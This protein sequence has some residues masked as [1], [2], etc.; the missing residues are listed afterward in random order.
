[1]G[2]RLGRKRLYALMK[3][4]ESLTS[5]AGAG[6]EGNIGNQ[7][8]LRDGELISTDITIDLAAAAGAA[9]SFPMK[10]VVD[11]EGTGT[12]MIIGVSSSTAT[13]SSLGYW[14]GNGS[15]NI[16][17]INGT[18][19]G[20]DS[21]GILTSGELMCVE[22]PAGGTT[23]VGLVLG[24]NLSGSGA[25]ADSGITALIPPTVQALG[26]NSVFD[27]DADVDNKYVYLVASGS[28]SAAFTAGKFV[29]RL[30]GWN[31]FDDV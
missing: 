19:S 25:T 24:D 28:T 7:T 3:E 9:F 27:I 20:G 21:I 31:V 4:G 2:K 6:V 1:M 29:L 14:T 22:T 13:S 10:A 30:Y 8:R 26:V 5:T 12:I 18:S 11:G 15:A 16:M 17:Q 23:T